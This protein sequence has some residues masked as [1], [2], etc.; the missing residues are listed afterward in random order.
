MADQIHSARCKITSKLDRA[1]DERLL[2][3]HARFPLSILRRVSRLSRTRATFN[4]QCVIARDRNRQI[5]TLDRNYTLA[6][7]LTEISLFVKRGANLHTSPSRGNVVATLLLPTGHRSNE[8]PSFFSLYQ[9]ISTL[10]CSFPSDGFLF[11]RTGRKR[12]RSIGNV[13]NTQTTAIG[14]MYAVCII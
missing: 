12:G 14:C 9:E 7:P 2:D 3:S 11:E 6:I 10:S 8:R 1:C 4:A 5:F 13:R